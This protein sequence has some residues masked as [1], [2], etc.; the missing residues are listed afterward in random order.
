MRTAEETAILTALL[1][2]RAN[3]KRARVSTKTIRRLSQRRTIRRAFL[4][5]LEQHLDDLGVIL[6]ELDRGG[7]GLIAASTLDGARAVTA[8]KFL[9]KEL[10]ALRD[11]AINFDRLRLEVEEEFVGGEEHEEE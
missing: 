10:S 8:K 9:S 11:K 4:D 3:E 2:K 6:I 1:L 5:M 7:Y